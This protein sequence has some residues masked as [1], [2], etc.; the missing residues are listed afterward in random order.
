[1]TLLFY[2]LSRRN[3]SETWKF[4]ERLTPRDVLEYFEESPELRQYVDDLRK[5]PFFAPQ[6]SQDATETDLQLLQDVEAIERAFGASGSPSLA[7][8][9]ELLTGQRYYSGGTY[10]RLKKA[11]GAWESSSSDTQN[12]GIGTQN[13]DMPRLVA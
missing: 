12:K 10:Y 9:A 6:T 11:L 3:V 1:M 7:D 2:Q 4:I 5:S 8:V 13:D